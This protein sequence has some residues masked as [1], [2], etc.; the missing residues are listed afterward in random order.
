MTQAELG[1]ELS[2]DMPEEALA[3]NAG[4]RLKQL[5]NRSSEH[6]VASENVTW[7]RADLGSWKFE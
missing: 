1:S 4:L 3:G 2:P 7:M 5:P 6:I